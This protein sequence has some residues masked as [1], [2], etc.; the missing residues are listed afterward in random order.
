MNVRVVNSAERLD[1]T[2]K[3]REGVLVATRNELDDILYKFNGNPK[4]VATSFLRKHGVIVYYTDTLEGFFDIL[5]Y[6]DFIESADLSESIRKMAFFVSSFGK[7]GT[8]LYGMKLD[9]WILSDSVIIV[10]DTNRSPLHSNS[11][12]IFLHTCSRLMK[13]AM[14]NHFPLRGAIGGGDFYKDGELMVSTALTDAAKYEKAQNWL[15]AILTPKAVELID[16]AKEAEINSQGTT[17]IDLSSEFFKQRLRF[18]DIHWYSGRKL[19]GPM[20]DKTYYIK[21]YKMADSDWASKYLPD[22]FR[23]PEKVA[24][25]HCLYGEN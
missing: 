10:V 11:L 22:Y 13:V 12:K 4:E 2:I 3:G 9:H 1:I 7:S 19:N 8:D 5:G 25:S 17:E 18:G 14:E 24:N 21:P 6:A 20:P 23:D 16:K 15:G